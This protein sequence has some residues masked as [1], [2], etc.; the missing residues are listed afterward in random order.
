MPFD[1]APG[2]PVFGQSQDAADDPWLPAELVAHDAWREPALR[3]KRTQ[4]SLDRAELRLDLLHHERAAL[5]AP[6]EKVDRSTLSEDRK[7]SLRAWLPAKASMCF[8][9]VAD[10]RGMELVQQTVAGGT[11]IRSANVQASV[12]RGEDLLD[13]A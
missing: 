10:K 12:E 3:V 6:S 8:D 7:G 11:V 13:V 2:R 1:R 4:R 9:A 5:G